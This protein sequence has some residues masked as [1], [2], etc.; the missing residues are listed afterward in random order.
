MNRATLA[1]AW[2]ELRFGA[3]LAIFALCAYPYAPDSF[4]KIGQ[5]I[6][7]A[8]TELAPAPDRVGE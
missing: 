5:A 3:Q 4:G 2:P 6:A 7:A 1:R 8:A